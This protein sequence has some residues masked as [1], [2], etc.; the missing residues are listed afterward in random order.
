MAAL[1]YME[2]L[3]EARGAIGRL[4]ARGLYLQ[5]DTYL[6]PSELLTLRKANVLPPLDRDESWAIIVAPGP[7]AQSR[8]QGRPAPP[9]A[10]SGHYDDTILVSVGWASR[11]KRPLAC[12]V[13]AALY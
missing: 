12:R 1:L 10:K 6:R 2:W 4:A 8:L 13:L 9:R 7:D 3:C 11:A 5:F